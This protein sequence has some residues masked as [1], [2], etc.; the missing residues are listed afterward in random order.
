MVRKRIHVAR[1]QPF[2][3]HLAPGD[4]QSLAGEALT[5]DEKYTRRFREKHPGEP[6]AAQ[7]EFKQTHVALGERLGQRIDEI[8][9]VLFGRLL[10]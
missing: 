10:R 4:H 9:K 2:E 7:A 1:E 6:Q 5:L 8:T 3:I